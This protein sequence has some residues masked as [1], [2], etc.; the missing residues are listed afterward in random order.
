MSRI[1][2]EALA[3]IEDSIPNLYE[4]KAV[5]VCAG[6]SYAGVK[7][8]T[9]HVGICYSLLDEQAAHCCRIARRAGGSQAAQRSSWR[10]WPGRGT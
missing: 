1:I 5:R 7:L 2:D 6:W 9:G 8:S 4:V 3:I 10:G